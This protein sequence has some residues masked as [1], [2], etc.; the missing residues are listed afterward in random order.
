MTEPRVTAATALLHPIALVALAVWLVNDHW[1]KAALPGLVTGKLS[2]VAGLIVFPLIPV[3]AAA[4]WRERRG[5][6]PPGMA[7][8]AAWLVATGAA[9]AAIKLA[10][11]AAWAYRHGLALAQWPVRAG[12][13]LISAGDVPQL[14][15]VQLTMDVSDLLT[16][17][18]LLVPWALLAPVLRATAQSRTRTP[19]EMAEVSVSSTR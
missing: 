3:C 15:P 14:Q 12:W 16:L 8:T 10:D 19:S 1:A 2:D 13:Q 18:A 5:G 17:P 4:L 11:P 7:W 9:M 6:S